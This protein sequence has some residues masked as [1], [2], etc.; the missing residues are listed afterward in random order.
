M[1]D[2]EASP[3]TAEATA[4][5]AIH[6]DQLVSYAAD[7]WLDDIAVLTDEAALLAILRAGAAAGNAQVLGEVTHVFPNGAVTAALVLSQSHL[8]IHTWP[9]FSLANIDL[10]AYGILNGNA[11]I[12]H[13]E[14]AL[15]PV[16]TNITRLI[17]DVLP[18]AT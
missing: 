11:I 6:V 13:V 8:T 17:R 14:A 1:T 9:E 15:A 12:D 10:L 3:T 2:P 16:R 4:E 5:Q 18:T 7:V